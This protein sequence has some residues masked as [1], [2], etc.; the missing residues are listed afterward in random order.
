MT[1]PPTDDLRGRRHQRGP[2]L[3]QAATDL[4]T[5]PARISELERGTR[6]GTILANIYRH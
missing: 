4:N 2:T 5:S 3:A 6:L 1:T